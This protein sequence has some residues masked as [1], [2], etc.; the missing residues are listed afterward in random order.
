MFGQPNT[1][2]G[3]GGGGFGQQNTAPVFGSPTPAPG[4]IFG[5]PTPAFGQAPAAGFGQ[6][7]PSAF[8]QQ[9]QQ[10]QQAPASLFGTT[11]T[12]PTSFGGYRAPAPTGLFGAPAPA[13]TGFG[14]GTSLFG[15]PVPAPSG[16]GTAAPSGGLFGSQAPAPT[17]FGTSGG[18]GA[19]AQAPTG[20]FGAPAPAPTGFGAPGPTGF[21][22]PVGGGGL[23]GSPAGTAGPATG[24]R[25]TPYQVTSRQDGTSTINLQSISAMTQY[26]DQSHEEL[27]YADY[28]QGNRGTAAP[29]TSAYG[30]YGAPVT[31]APVGGLFGSAPAPTSTFGS[32]GG[33]GLFGSSPATGYGAA[34]AT[35]TFGQTP[36]ASGGLFGSN[37]APAPFGAAPTS[38]F[39]APTS[40]FGTTSGGGLFGSSPAT[41]YGGAPAPTAF[42]QTPA[43]GGLFGSSNAPASFGA[44]PAPTGLFGS[45]AAPSTFGS[46]PAPF[47]SPGPA[48]SLFGQTPASGGLFGSNPAPA[49]FGQ[50]QAPFGQ[51]PAPFGHAPAP[52][53]QAP[54]APGGGLFAPAP[55]FGSPFA[56]AL[57]AAQQYQQQPQ[58]LFAPNAQIV[59]PA[60]NEV[61][62]QQ[63]RAMDNQLNEMK[64]MEVWKGPRASTSPST[65]PTSLHDSES[66]FS[67]TTR[68]AALAYNTSRSAAKIRPR[69][70]AQTEP[71]KSS[72]PLS[73]STRRDNSGL[74]S[75][76]AF[77]RS[78]QLNLVIRPDSLQRPRKF[79]LQLE[80]HGPSSPAGLPM[81]AIQPPPTDDSPADVP[82]TDP[83][84]S[85]REPQNSRSSASSLREAPATSPGYEYYQ[86]VIGSTNEASN[87]PETPT[88]NG[89]PNGKPSCVPK[90]TKRGYEVSPSI[91]E[92]STMSEADLASVRRFA[93]KRP[94]YGM[95][96]WEGSVDV[97]GADL[98]AIVVIEDKDVSVYGMD[99]EKGTKP[100][101]GTKLNRAAVITFNGVYPK[102][103]ARAS[104]EVKEKFAKKIE[105]T[106]Q[107]IGAE[108]ITY[109]SNTGV[110]KIRVQ[111][112]SRY[113][114]IDEDSDEE[115]A[116]S[117]NADL[118]SESTPRQPKSLAKRKVRSSRTSRMAFDDFELLESADY[119]DSDGNMVNDAEWTEMDVVESVKREAEEAARAISEATK[120]VFGSLTHRNEIVKEVTFEDEGD[121]DESSMDEPIVAAAQPDADD[122]LQAS[123]GSSLCS[124]LLGN[125]KTDA[126]H[127]ACGTRMG[128]SF[129]V[130]WLPDGSFLKLNEA[131]DPM[132]MSLVK[133]RPVLSDGS[134]KATAVALLEVQRR[135]AVVH[136]FGDDKC[137]LFSLSRNFEHTASVFPS[138]DDARHAFLLLSRLFPIDGDSSDL[139]TLDQGKVPLEARRMAAVYKLLL[140]LCAADVSKATISTADS[141][142]TVFAALCGGNLEKSCDLAAEAGYTMLSV[143]LATSSDGRKDV[144]RLLVDVVESRDLSRLTNPMALR[145]I[146]DAGGEFKWEDENFRCGEKT[147]DWRHRLVLRVLQDPDTSLLQAL[148]RYESSTLAGDVPFPQPRYME[149]TTSQVKSTFFRLLRFCA[150]PQNMSVCEAIDPSGYT[151]FLHDYYLSFHLVCAISSL[152]RNLSG[153]FALSPFEAEY[154]MDGYETQL[155]MQGAWEWAVFVSLCR[156]GEGAPEI[157]RWKTK[158]AKNLVLRHYHDGDRQSEL[159]R[160]FLERKVGVP[161]RWFEEALCYRAASNG[162]YIRCIEHAN[163]FDAELG[164]AALV[165]F[166]LPRLFFD[167]MNDHKPSMM[168]MFASEMPPDS[169]ALAMYRFFMLEERVMALSSGDE[170]IVDSDEVFELLETFAYVHD[171]LSKLNDSLRNNAST[172]LPNAFLI[173][174]SSKA[175][176]LSS[177]VSE[178][179]QRLSCLKVL[180]DALSHP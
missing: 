27:R 176:R 146:R 174:V 84:P 144:M 85:P 92:F 68:P 56:Q 24:T 155:T 31:A 102:E 86:Q 104:Q 129:R 94:G 156:I 96:E 64:K 25:A 49:P 41:G 141:L 119:E 132:V 159:R 168:A 93:V 120:E 45:A 164:Q 166:V 34:P 145:I 117:L 58:P 123:Y 60:V 72:V 87:Q 99:E 178:T 165:E 66:F 14:G 98:D 161:S 127:S 16:F 124:T 88:A 142:S 114:L 78:S 50:A 70:F 6:A 140:D 83:T 22:A 152:A 32:T 26:Q 101:E 179:L 42:G 122:F 35:T 175:V 2:F 18:F 130:G 149:G 154:I 177:M 113:G 138:D 133:V 79:G 5:S 69:G 61:I 37:L 147:L 74:M 162:D 118:P 51:A 115:N 10:Q 8:G 62:E 128:R 48:P 28:S 76:E 4:G 172:L 90:L 116:L 148:Q 167:N 125:A 52:F 67:P 171:F 75:P 158:R 109:D 54:P 135:D 71:P 11:A 1:P 44:A 112:F 139:V 29:P 12:A 170:D 150:D 160:D 46:S 110:W 105:K 163:A 43:S 121:E 126:S 9:Q 38:T 153:P 95:V 97:R 108:F 180:L 73:S 65:T 55:A 17:G 173:P 47:G 40:T 111:H 157:Q 100:E 33:G 91:E 36:A 151:P 20:L 81:E 137:P 7:Q 57:P 59:A 19:P 136:S 77:V 80:S 169:L 21:G 3:G 63:L 13:P 143:A 82:R 53:G 131:S 39:G 103:G 89:A 106:T 15:A 30:G 134:A 23:F 107:K